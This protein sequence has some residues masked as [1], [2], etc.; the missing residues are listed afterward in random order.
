MNIDED[1]SDVFQRVG[2][3]A[4]RKGRTGEAFIFLPYWYFDYQGRQRCTTTVDKDRSARSVAGRRRRTSKNMMRRGR[5]A[6]RLQE[7]TIV[8]DSSPSSSEDDSSETQT[9]GIDDMFSW[10]DEECV[11][12]L[13]DYQALVNKTNWSEEDLAKRSKIA[14][15]WREF[16][17]ARCR[18]KV[19]LRFLQEQGS[20]EEIVDIDRTVPKGRCCNGWGCTP[21]TIHG[22]VT[23]VPPIVHDVGAKPSQGTMAWF[24]L[25]HLE[26]WC[27]EAAGNSE[28]YRD[29]VG[30]PPGSFVLLP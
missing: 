3:V 11:R 20:Q 17:N 8:A 23:T 18:R 4:R 2:R 9:Q 1:L 30:Q 28:L 10:E 7:G 19:L 13:S 29:M 22:I 6:S 12:A 14:R 15:E 5:K 16:C 27:N 25:Q 24:A 21:G 26:K